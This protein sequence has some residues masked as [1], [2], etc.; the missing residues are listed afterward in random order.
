MFIG[1]GLVLTGAGIMIG[2]AA[3]AAVTRLMASLLFRTNPIDPPTY[4][5]VAATLVFVA[6]LACYLPARRVTSVNPVE[7]LRTE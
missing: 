7:A 3:S 2:L 5:A 1:Q 4:A 6:F